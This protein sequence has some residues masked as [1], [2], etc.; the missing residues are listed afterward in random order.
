[1]SLRVSQGPTA[2]AC[3]KEIYGETDTRTNGRA[4]VRADNAAPEQSHDEA[5]GS[6]N[7]ES[8]SKKMCGVAVRAACR[9]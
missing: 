9:G 2:R 4:E 3:W 6:S 1:M 7:R 8:D 5:N